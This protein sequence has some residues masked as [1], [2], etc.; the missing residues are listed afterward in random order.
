MFTD[1]KWCGKT[2]KKSHAVYQMTPMS[3][4]LSDLEVKVT[5]AV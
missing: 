2:N 4:T 3:M 1:Y 5:S